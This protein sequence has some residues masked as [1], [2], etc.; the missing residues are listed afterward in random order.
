[1]A[2]TPRPGGKIVQLAVFEGFVEAEAAVAQLEAAG[3][4][5]MR[6][7]DDGNSL[8]NLASSGGFP[9]LVFE[10]D[11]DAARAVLATESSEP[12]D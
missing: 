8:P 1:M 3:I 4:K 2:P 5:G 9:V 12:A 7:A 10:D 11:L 6:G